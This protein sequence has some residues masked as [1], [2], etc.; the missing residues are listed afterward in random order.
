MPQV[1]T[2]PPDNKAPNKPPSGHK[3]LLVP[4]EEAFWK[5]YSPHHEFPVSGATSI[6]LHAIAIVFLI[7]M[8]WWLFSLTRK[9]SDVPE[10]IPVAMSGEDTK[11]RASG[12]GQSG[13]T[14]GAD[15]ES[16]PEDPAEGDPK[17]DGD[18]AEAPALKDLPDDPAVE[19][20][21]HKDGSRT[22]VHGKVLEDLGDIGR[23]AHKVLVRRNVPKTRKGSKD[24]DGGSGGDKGPGRGKGKGRGTGPKKG[25]LE[26]QRV[27]EKRQVRWQVIFNTRSGADYQD[28][29]YALGATLVVAE[30][31]P[32]SNQLLQYRLVIRREKLAQSPVRPTPA[33][34]SKI[35]GIFW[36]DDKP[37]SV[38]SLASALGIRPP[39][40]FACFFPR[41]VE[42]RLRDL[43]RKKYPGREDNIEKT[44]FRVVPAAGGPNTYQGKQGRYDLVCEEVMT[45]R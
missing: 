13:G 38:R 6:A 34:V 32:G 11:G 30:F 22:I 4:P 25:E 7:L 29:L 28:Q 26:E 43:E 3:P 37:E 18:P 5:R 23:K 15:R 36:I 24:K 8:T 31:Q 21:S 39:P 42:L 1:P 20:P 27:R 16:V 2:T 19:V 17:E 44:I 14:R 35:P 41:K 33:D 9:P 40:L 10:L 12:G 45:K